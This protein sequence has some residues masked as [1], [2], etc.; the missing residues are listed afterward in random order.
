MGAA[1]LCAMTGTDVLVAENQAA[2]IAG[3]LPVYLW[4]FGG[5]CY[6][7]GHGCAAGGGLPHRG[8]GKA[9]LFRAAC[10]GE[11]LCSRWSLQ[12]IALIL[13]DVRDRGCTHSFVTPRRL[14]CAP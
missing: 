4:P 7:G 1:F 9:L 8:V 2:Y 11:I 10:P 12:N 3:W 13:R 6:R 14:L 5:R